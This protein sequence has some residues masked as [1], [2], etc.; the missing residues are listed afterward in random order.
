MSI[1]RIASSALVA[2]S[3]LGGTLARADGEPVDSPFNGGDVTQ[4][5][6]GMGSG[7]DTDSGCGGSNSDGG[8]DNP[9]YPGEGDDGA[10]DNP[11]YPGEGDNGGI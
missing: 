6:D 4:P 7:S 8:I 11:S 5:D 1:L 2:L 10:I 3:L 9:S